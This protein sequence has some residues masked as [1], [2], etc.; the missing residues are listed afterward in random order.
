MAEKTAPHSRYVLLRSDS[1][2]GSDKAGSLIMPSVRQRP[3]FDLP[4]SE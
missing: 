4:G 1:F 3:S 2:L